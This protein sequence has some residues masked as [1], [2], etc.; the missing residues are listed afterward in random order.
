M[1][2]INEFTD[3]GAF[4]HA[5]CA[6]ASLQSWLIDKARIHTTIREI[7]QLA[8][9]TANGTGW[10]GVEVAGL[11][12]G[13]QIHFVTND[14]LP[15]WIMNPGGGYID[16]PAD[17]PAYLAATQGGCL[18]LPNVGAPIPKP[19]PIPEPP[20]QGDDDVYFLVTIQGN[21]N[22]GVYVLGGGFYIGVSTPAD[23]A[24]FREAGAKSI[25][26]SPAQHQRYLAAAAAKGA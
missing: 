18:V 3:G 21:P 23:A 12:F 2:V 16:P 20:T 17:F 7:E 9:T 22:A 15:G 6:P 4:E 19:Q 11:H 25:V 14:P 10:K 13:Y 1:T 26:I 8:G 24:A 5:D